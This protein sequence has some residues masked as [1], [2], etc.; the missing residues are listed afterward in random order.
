VQI[1]VLDNDIVVSGSGDPISV[2]AIKQ[3]PTYGTAALVFVDT[4]PKKVEYTPNADY[5]GNDTFWYTAASGSVTDDA[6]V[7]VTVCPNFWTSL[8]TILYYIFIFPFSWLLQLLGL[9]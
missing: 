2:S 7:M 1:N 9:A 5:C 6:K 3:A 4:D 8:G